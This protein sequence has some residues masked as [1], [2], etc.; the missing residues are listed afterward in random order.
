[1]IFNQDR[2][3]L[4]KNRFDVKLISES[5]LVH[6]S[7]PGENLALLWVAEEICESLPPSP[8]PANRLDGG[9]LDHRLVIMMMTIILIISLIT[10]II[11][12]PLAC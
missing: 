1:M 5:F 4:Q 2:G 12:N 10:N 6:I 9:A 8:V 3:D 11:S 7:P